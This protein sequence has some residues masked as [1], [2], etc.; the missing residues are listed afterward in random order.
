M[1]TKKTNPRTHSQT[2]KA[3]SISLQMFT[4]HSKNTLLLCYGNK[5]LYSSSNDISPLPPTKVYNCGDP[6]IIMVHL[7]AFIYWPT[8]LY[9]MVSNTIETEATP[10]S[11]IIKCTYSNTTTHIVIYEHTENTSGPDERLRNPSTAFNSPAIR[12]TCTIQSTYTGVKKYKYF[13]CNQ[14]HMYY[15]VYIHGCK[16]IRILVGFFCCFFFKQISAQIKWDKLLP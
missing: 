3:L 6:Y 4:V 8:V 9:F 1:Q 10:L 14:N 2:R 15:S 13:T 11:D 12:I 7:I 16:E 5:H